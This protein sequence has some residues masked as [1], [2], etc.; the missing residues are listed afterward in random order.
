MNFYISLYIYAYYIY[1]YIGGILVID[2]LIDVPYEENETKLI[3]FAQYLRMIFQQSNDSTDQR[4][5]R[6]ASKAL[7]HLAR[8]GGTLA[9]DTVEFEVKRALEW[10]EGDRSEQRRYAAVLVLKELAENTPTLFNVHVEKFLSHIW[11]SL[12]FSYILYITIFYTKNYNIIA[13]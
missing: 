11:V 8:S 4:L 12:L 5:L 10:L 1:I 2:E 6:E 7:G 3:R 13:N 9:A